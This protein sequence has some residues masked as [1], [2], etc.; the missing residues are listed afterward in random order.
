M[1]CI[2]LRV[3]IKGVGQGLLTLFII[4]IAVVQGNRPPCTPLLLLLLND[5]VWVFACTCLCVSFCVS[6]CTFRS[7]SPESLFCLSRSVSLAV[8]VCLCGCV[9]VCVCACACVG[10]PVCVCVCVC[11]REREREIVC[12]CVRVCASKRTRTTVFVTPCFPPLN[13]SLIRPERR[14]VLP[15]CCSLLL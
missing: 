2:I 14:Q 4:T 5:P 1:S 6:V 12:L 9:C 15:S 10:V 13:L 7:L 8:H 3:V 11:E